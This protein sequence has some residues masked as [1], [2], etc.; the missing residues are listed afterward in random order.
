MQRIDELALGITGVG[1]DALDAHR[2]LVGGEGLIDDLAQV[3]AVERVGKR[4]AQVGRQIL[5]DAAPDLFVGRE[6]DTQLAVGQ[7]RVRQQVFRHGHDDGDT[8]LVV[9]AQQRRATGGYDILADFRQ[10]V[11]RLL[12]REHLRRVVGQHDLA[13]VVG[14]MHDRLDAAGMEGGC[15]VYMGQKTDHRRAGFHGRRDRGEHRAVAGQRHFLR[16]DLFQFLHKQVQQVKLDRR[17]R[18][19]ARFF[20]RLRVDLAVAHQAFF[21]FAVKLCACHAVFPCS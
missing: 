14:A 19:G 15:S 20:I 8:G 5:V 17:A 4:R 13:A 18:R 21:E 3:G 6:G 11:G 2:R 10:Q 1:G 9:G 12:G 7:L 16:A